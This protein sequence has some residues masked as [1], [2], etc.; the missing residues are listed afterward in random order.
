MKKV[1][2]LEMK[3]DYWHA[4]IM[5]PEFFKENKYSGYKEI[6]GGELGGDMISFTRNGS[7]IQARIFPFYLPSCVSNHP[8]V[9]KTVLKPAMKVIL[10]DLATIDPLL[11]D[12]RRLVR[13]KKV[14]DTVYYEKEKYKANPFKVYDYS[15]SDHKLTDSLLKIKDI[16]Q[17]LL[18]AE[19]HGLH[20]LAQSVKQG[21]NG[22]INYVE[23]KTLNE[24]L[25]SMVNIYKSIDE[26]GKIKNN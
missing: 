24:A 26:I 22:K 13:E 17:R 9:R 18:S 11:E 3:A 20:R 10:E 21:G 23:G 4:N 1:K 2:T 5:L 15:Y 8:D 12:I 16:P 14:Q 19:Y 6:P 25:E 7:L